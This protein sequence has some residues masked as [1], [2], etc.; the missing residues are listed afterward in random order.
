MTKAGNFSQSVITNSSFLIVS[1]IASYLRSASF[2][3]C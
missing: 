2:S 3:S 1:L